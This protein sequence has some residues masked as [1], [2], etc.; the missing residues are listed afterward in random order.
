MSY[1]IGIIGSGHIGRGLATHLAKTTYPVL[2]TNSRGPASLTDLVAS[3][4]GSLQAADFSQTI[5][6]ADVLFIAVPW[7]QVPDLANQLQGYNGKILVDATNNIVSVSPFQLADTGGKPTGEYVA[8]LFPGQRVVKAFNTLA[9]ATLVQPS[10]TSL[11]NSVIIISGDDAEAKKE[12]A[13]ITRAMGFEPI[14]I[15]TFRQGGHLQDVGGAL[16]G[17]ELIKVNR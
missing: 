4:G 2:I 7:A 17:I 3:I 16:S 15:G 12:V 8:A 11:G 5:A 13:D 6:Q 14:D 9:A 10:Q 1:T